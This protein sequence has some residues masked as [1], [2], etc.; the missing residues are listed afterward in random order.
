MMGSILRP[1]N[2]G[3]V[4]QK[5]KNYLGIPPKYLSDVSGIKIAWMPDLKQSWRRPT[6]E[7]FLE[8][9]GIG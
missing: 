8:C 1:D 5:L 3:E 6:Y 4:Y 2:A 7:E 9:Y